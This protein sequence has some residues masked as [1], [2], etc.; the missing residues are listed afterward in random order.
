MMVKQSSKI[1]VTYTATLNSS[2]VV[3]KNGNSNEVKLEYSNDPNGTGK[4]TTTPDVVKVFTLKI[5]VDKVKDSAEGDALTGAGF[6][7]YKKDANGQYQVV[8]FDNDNKVNPDGANTELKGENL[9]HF[10]WSGL[11]E[12]DYKLVETTTPAGFNTAADIEFTIKVN[13]TEGE[14]DKL[15]LKDV[16]AG[17]KFTIVTA[18]NDPDANNFV[19]NTK[20]VNK[21]GSNLPSTGGMGTKLFYTIGGLLMAGAAIVLVIK[22]RR[23]SAE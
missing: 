12:G 4:G 18:E 8:K 23:S 11:G 16:S 15:V 21:Q 14:K 5:T 10:Q 7:L 9:T 20:V 3:G 22:K 1:V 2:A 6:T 13:N 17:D 19:F